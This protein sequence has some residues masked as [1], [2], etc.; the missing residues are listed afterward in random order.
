MGGGTEGNG[1]G[2]TLISRTWQHVRRDEKSLP[3]HLPS[4]S[5]S[6]HMKLHYAIEKQQIWPSSPK[7]DNRKKNNFLTWDVMVMPTGPTGPPSPPPTPP[8]VH[9]DPT[10]PHHNTVQ[11]CTNITG[12]ILISHTSTQIHHA[13]KTLTHTSNDTYK[14]TPKFSIFTFFSTQKVRYPKTNSQT[15][16]QHV[17]YNN[18]QAP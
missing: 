12:L 7:Q 10:L 6:K 5:P 2:G 8:Q 11:R 18:V 16:P 15:Y 14:R 1:E 9:K 13:L 17:Q 4:K 3:K